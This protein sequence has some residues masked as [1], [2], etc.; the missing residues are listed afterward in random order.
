MG[1]GRYRLPAHVDARIMAMLDEG[2]AKFGPAVRDRYAALIL[3]AMQ[4]V[5]DV[6]DRPGS[7]VD[8]AID[9]HVLF[10][11]LRH[12][13][14]RMKSSRRIGQ[15]RH[16]LVYEV[17]ADGIIDILGLIPDM[18]PKGIALPRFIPDRFV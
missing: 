13:R 3:R 11:H 18:I 4:D 8:Q 6:P 17:G 9:S 5:A 2:A 12:S 10:Y 14:A 7:R 16:I 15:P 1:Q